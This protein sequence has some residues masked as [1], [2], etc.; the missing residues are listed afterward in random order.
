MDS[1]PRP[2]E[3]AT[4]FSHMVVVLTVVIAASILVAMGKLDSSNIATV[5]GAAIGYAG[6]LT[7]GRRS[8]GNGR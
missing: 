8:D 7:V 1:P 2:S 6:G 3:Y 5:Y 4:T